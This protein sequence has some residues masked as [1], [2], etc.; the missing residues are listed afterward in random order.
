MAAFWKPIVSEMHTHC[1]QESSYY[2]PIKL[3][4]QKQVV[5]NT[6]ALPHNL[7]NKLSMR[8]LSKGKNYGFATKTTHNIS[9]SLCT[10]GH[11]KGKF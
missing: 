4:V 11:Y 1:T 10:K 3:P 6:S 5:I 9:Q 8:F 7:I 2:L